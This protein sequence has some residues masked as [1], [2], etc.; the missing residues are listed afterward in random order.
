MVGVA[1]IFT[2]CLGGVHVGGFF[3][4]EGCLPP[5]DTVTSTVSW[6]VGAGTG[7]GAGGVTN[8]QQP[9]GVGRT[10]G[11][12]LVGEIR[13]GGGDVGS[14]VS[15]GG[16]RVSRAAKVRFGTAPRLPDDK[17]ERHCSTSRPRAHS[18]TIS[19]GLSIAPLAACAAL[20]GAR[21]YRTT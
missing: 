12:T 13:F 18:A 16:G 14:R 10:D 20:E 17:E 3:F 11:G 7:A 5:L 8:K 15:T 1:G 4:A 2:G 19:V 21:S 9:R 6:H